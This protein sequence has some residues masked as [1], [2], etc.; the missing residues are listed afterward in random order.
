MNV[1]EILES[2]KNSGKLDDTIS[3]FCDK[4]NQLENNHSNIIEILGI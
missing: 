4:L 1:C 3:Y 2:Y